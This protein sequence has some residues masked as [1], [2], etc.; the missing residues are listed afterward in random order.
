VN[1]DPIDEVLVAWELETQRAREQ[2]Y[3]GDGEPTF[4]P[5]RSSE[6][7]DI[8]Y[9][10]R[11]ASTASTVTAAE[12]GRGLIADDLRAQLAG[13]GTEPGPSGV[14]SREPARPQP[15]AR[16]PLPLDPD[17]HRPQPPQDPGPNPR[18]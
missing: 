14:H 12:L 6:E 2:L 3:P 1:G 16:S 18:L 7:P 8:V 10:S 9:L 17:R 13:I 15:D 11:L 5:I 4:E